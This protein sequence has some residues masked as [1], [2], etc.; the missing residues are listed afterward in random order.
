[1]TL[2]NIIGKFLLLADQKEGRFL[3]DEEIN[4]LTE[5]I[6]RKSGKALGIDKCFI[7][8]CLLALSSLGDKEVDLK[9]REIFGRL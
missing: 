3:T 5:K 9:I 7:R 4:G 6:Y 1:M 2:L 8:K